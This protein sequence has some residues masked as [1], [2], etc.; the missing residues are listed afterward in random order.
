M[1][2]GGVVVFFIFLYIITLLISILIIRWV[3]RIN[4][5]V[6]EL[7]A[8]RKLLQ[9]GAFVTGAPSPILEGRVVEDSKTKFYKN[10]MIICPKCGHQNEESSQN[11][12]KCRINLRWA[13]ENPTVK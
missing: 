5:I 8:I 12:A 9:K 3:F 11:C 13:M 6:N 2:E 1:L 4:D 10:G 7:E